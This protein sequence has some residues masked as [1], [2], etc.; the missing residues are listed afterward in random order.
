MPTC[1]QCGRLLSA[2][3]IALHKRLINRGAREHL[4]LSCMAAYF[5]CSE[6]ILREKID[7]FRSIGCLLFQPDRAESE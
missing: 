3:E 4:C 6:D 5:A 7:Y 2:D 1:K